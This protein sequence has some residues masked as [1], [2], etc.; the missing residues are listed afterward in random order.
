MKKK[1]V[2]IIDDNVDTAKSLGTLLRLYGYDA[3]VANDGRSGIELAA[4]IRPDLVILDVQ[5]PGMDGYQVLDQIK[6]PGINTRVVICSGVHM[7]I[8]DAIKSI[9]LGACDRWVKPVGEDE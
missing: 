9:K 7:D 6:K 8:Q 5:M 3:V 4:R 1:H 2:L